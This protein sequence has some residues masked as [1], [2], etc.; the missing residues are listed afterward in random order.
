MSGRALAMYGLGHGAVWTGPWR[1]MDGP[2]EMC[3]LGHG[4]LNLL[5]YPCD[6]LK[7]LPQWQQEVIGGV[8]I[9]L[10]LSVLVIDGCQ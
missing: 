6:K 4:V 8:I 9:L 10:W 1:Y 7:P 3:G 2:L 5:S